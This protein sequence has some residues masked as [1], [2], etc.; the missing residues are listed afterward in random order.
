MKILAITQA[1][2]GS[3]RLPGKILKEING[4]TLLEIH[5]TRILRSQ[6]I[7]MLKVA[8]TSEPDANKIVE[9]AHK[10]NVG[11]YRG[12]LNNVLE[13][14]FRTA[15][16]E[17]PDWVVRL[18]SDCPLIDPDLIDK[19]ILFAIENDLDYASNS[20]H[21][22]FPN[23]VDV[24]VFRYSALSRAF[25]EARLN[26]ELEH[27][28]PYIWKNS[29]FNGGLLFKSDCLMYSDD[30]SQYRITV[31]TLEDFE[32]IKQLI[33]KLGINK[34]WIEYIHLLK[35][36]VDIKKLNEKF[37]RNEGYEKSVKNDKY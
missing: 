30:F 21:P 18:T 12:S 13:R 25:K 17:N 27:V 16:P 7:T 6:L 3:S 33:E 4:H 36:N 19:V 34:P 14:F 31:D 28:T 26:S 5:L 23:G 35:E 8:T 10:L 29:S 20:L 1:R 24:E 2:I 15:E 11:V 9:I 22:T 32:V 37:S